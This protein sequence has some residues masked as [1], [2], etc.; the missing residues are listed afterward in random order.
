MPMNGSGTRGNI[1][2]FNASMM[3]Q[4]TYNTDINVPPLDTQV[5]VNHMMNNH[6][7]S[8]PLLNSQGI[9]VY[10]PN[11]LDLNN[12]MSISNQ[13]MQNMNGSQQYMGS[14]GNSQGSQGSQGQ[15]MSNS[16]KSMRP[17]RQRNQ[18]MSLMNNDQYNQ[19]N[20]NSRYINTDYNPFNSPP[21]MTTTD[22]SFRSQQSPNPLLNN[23][24][25]NVGSHNILNLRAV[26][27][28]QSPDISSENGSY[29]GQPVIDVGRMSYNA[30]RGNTRTN[31]PLGNSVVSYNLRQRS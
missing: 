6:N 5:V 29:T 8:Y 13:N 21:R 27:G 17:K 26:E 30:S 11:G 3:I 4:P 19:M 14:M 2:Q 18:T 1:R 22:T 16:G 24:N 23:Q 31:S 25:N 20:T 12:P 15:M 9:K 7:V 28:R 10:N